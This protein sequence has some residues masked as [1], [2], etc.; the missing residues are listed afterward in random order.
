LLRRRSEPPPAIRIFPIRQHVHGEEH[1]RPVGERD[2]VSFEVR[3]EPEAGAA[4]GLRRVLFDA[5]LVED[6]DRVESGVPAFV[7]PTYDYRA[8]FLIEDDF[9]VIAG[10][11]EVARPVVRRVVAGGVAIEKARRR[12]RNVLDS[13]SWR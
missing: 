11:L 2:G 7:G 5:G 4:G 1:S 12:L 8:A 6:L 3:V 13:D 10:P 9:V